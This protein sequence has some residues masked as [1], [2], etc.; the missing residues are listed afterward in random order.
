GLVADQSLHG[1]LQDGHALPQRSM[2]LA[3]PQQVRV[4]LLGL[5]AQLGAVAAGH[6]AVAQQ[7][8]VCG[9]GDGIGIVDARQASGAGGQGLALGLQPAYLGF[10]LLTLLVQQA[11]ALAVAAG[12]DAQFRGAGQAQALDAAALGPKAVAAE[13]AV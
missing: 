5:Q 12:A 8:G 9:A 13:G 7:G 1:S 4:G 3:Q 6:L 11:G 10:G 2:L